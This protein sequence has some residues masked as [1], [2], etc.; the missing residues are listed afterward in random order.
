MEPPS[1]WII[2][3]T[4]GITISPQNKS[5]AAIS[6]S[7]IALFLV[8]P[9]LYPLVVAALD[10]HRPLL[11]MLNQLLAIMIIPLTHLL[12]RQLRFTASAR[13]VGRAACRA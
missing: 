5:C 4:I 13:P 6:L 7:P 12:A 1:I 2:R 3:A 9:P 10:V 8:R 11:L